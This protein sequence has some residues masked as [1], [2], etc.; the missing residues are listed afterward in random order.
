MNTKLKPGIVPIFLA[1]CLT[2]SMLL[3]YLAVAQRSE[4]SPTPPTK[5]E[6]K[7]TEA[8][9]ESQSVL[10]VA[11][12]ILAESYDLVNKAP[13]GAAVTFSADLGQVICFTRIKG[14]KEPAEITHVWYYDGKTMAK[15]P[16]H[17]GSSNWRTYSSKKLLPSWTG[18]WEVRILDESGAVLATAEFTVQ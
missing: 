1:V 10:E 18:Q 17:I 13:V 3:P 5:T 8:E 15:V 6:D 7:A 4:D 16:L 12:I 2:V 14:A 11:E 9:V